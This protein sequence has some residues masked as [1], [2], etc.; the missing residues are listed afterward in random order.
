[1]PKV[2]KLLCPWAATG[3]KPEPFDGTNT[4]NLHSQYQSVIRSLLYLMLG[5]HPDIVFAV[6]QMAK[7]AANPSDEHLNKAMYIM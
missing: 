1:M 5:T 2:L 4:S 7:F 3:Y 6:T